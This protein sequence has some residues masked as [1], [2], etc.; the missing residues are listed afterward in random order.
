MESQ[1]KIIKTL[2]FFGKESLSIYLLHYFFIF[3]I[4]SLRQPMID[5]GL[6]FVPLMIV[7]LTISLVIIGVALGA[8]SIISKSKLL[9][10]LLLGKN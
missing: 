9:S 8:S 3:P 10:M 4:S 5:M 7:S 1:S 6:E 2:Q